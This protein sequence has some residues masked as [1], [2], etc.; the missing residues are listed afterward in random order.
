MSGEGLALES[1][2]QASVPARAETRGGVLPP[3]LAARFAGEFSIPLRSDRPALLANFVETVDGVVAFG[4]DKPTAGGAEVSGHF[5]PDRFMM[6]LLRALADVVVMGAGTVRTGHRHEWTARQLEPE[7]EDVFA[8]WRSRLGLA[9]YPTLVVVTGTGDLDM[10]H[11]GLSNPEIP[12]IVATTDAGA[13]RL[14]AQEI[15]HGVVVR[16]LGDRVP[17][18]GVMDLIAGTG[19]R[20]ALCE[21]GPHL[22]GELLRAGFVDELFLTVAPQVIGRNGSAAR[23]SLVEGVDFAEAGRWA[24][25]VWIRRSANH[26]FLRY[27]FGA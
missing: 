26:L 8:A 11:H 18:A 20:L 16:P 5:E 3:E 2:W 24:E 27:R 4:G 15:P 7:L 1:L 17:T 9:P 23:L 6:A 22:L 14:A 25:L 19:A 12:V 13:Q 21:G 10:R